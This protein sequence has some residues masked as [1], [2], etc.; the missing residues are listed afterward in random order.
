MAA[1]VSIMLKVMQKK[2][3]VDNFSI[4]H[5][6]LFFDMGAPSRSAIS[7][8]ALSKLILNAFLP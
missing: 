7:T 8:I 2:L 3:H 1:D 6:N 5:A 4:V